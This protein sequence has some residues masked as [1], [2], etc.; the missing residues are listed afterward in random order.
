M[1][2]AR[3]VESLHAYLLDVASASVLRSALGTWSCRVVI[4]RSLSAVGPKRTCGILVVIE[5]MVAFSMR[6]KDT[7]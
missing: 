5:V 2:S 6:F 1:V 3:L 7:L 4:D